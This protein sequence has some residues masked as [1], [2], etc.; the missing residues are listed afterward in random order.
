MS[1]F[2]G[3]FFWKDGALHP[4]NDIMRE[5][6][7]KHFND[8]QLYAMTDLKFG[9][10]KIR[11]FLQ[12][13]SLHL[14]LDKLAT[15]MND[16]GYDMKAVFNAMRKGFSVSCTTIRLKNCVWRPMQEAMFDIESTT[17]LDTK[18][19]S[20]V[21]ENVNRFTCEQ[22]GIGINWPDRFNHEYEQQE[23]EA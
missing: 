17:E 22:F 8:G 2:E 23:Q 11:T 21:Y 10:K 9:G 7:E 1:N 20:E 5:E 4:Y 14:Y 6:C 13:K 16:A 15:A 19:I 18:Q 3:G 12:N